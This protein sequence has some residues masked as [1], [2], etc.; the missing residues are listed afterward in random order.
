YP[1]PFNPTTTIRY[2]LKQASDVKL[3]IYN[4]LGQE[5]RTLISAQQE[6]GYQSIV[7]DGRD[8]RGTPVASGI[9]IYQ[10]AANPATGVGQSFMSTRKMILMK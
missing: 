9:Y 1:N 8:N 6:A 3:K 10:L 7:W 5:V 2:G 4:L